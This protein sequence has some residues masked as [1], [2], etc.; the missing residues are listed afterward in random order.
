MTYRRQHALMLGP[1]GDMLK[2]EH[3]STSPSFADDSDSDDSGYAPSA[4]PNRYLEYTK[5]GTSARLIRD[6][7]TTDRLNTVLDHLAQVFPDTEVELLRQLMADNRGPSQLAAIVE[8]VVSSPALIRSRRRL[9]HNYVA[10]WERFRTREYRAAVSRVLSSHFKQYLHQSTITNVLAQKNSSFTNSLPLLTEI[11]T[12]R[13]HRWTLMRLFRRRRSVTPFSALSWIG[14]TGC[15]ELELELI[16]LDKPRRA[17]LCENDERAARAANEDEYARAGQLIECECCFGDYA[18]EDLSCCSEGHFFCHDCLT[19]S[20]KEGLYGQGVLRGKAFV[21]C[22]SAAADPPCRATVPQRV[23]RAAISESLYSEF[24]HAQITDFLAKNAAVKGFVVCPF[25]DYAE[26]SPAAVSSCNFS[27]LRLSLTPTTL[28][29]FIGAGGLIFLLLLLPMI[30]IGALYRAISIVALLSIPQKFYAKAF[31]SVEEWYDKKIMEIVHGV[32][33]KRHGSAFV[34]KNP[35]CSRI[36]CTECN[37]EFLPFHKCFEQEEDRMRVYIEKA[38]ADA[39]KRTC[40][41]CRVSFIKS[42]GCN[43]LTCVCGYSMCY[44]CRKDIRQESYQHFCDH[45]RPIP[46]SACTECDRCD[47]YKIEDEA[48][49]IERAAKEAEA[50]FIRSNGLPSGLDV[51]GKVI[52]P[53]GHEV[54]MN[55]GIM[56]ALESR[57]IAMLDAIIAE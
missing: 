14:R 13:T 9:R 3:S 43:K 1:F 5:A 2:Y 22:I 48:I 24:E 57:C 29:R 51:S 41:V 4:S 26:E 54:A 28:A 39:V 20:V 46:G 30:V 16:E 42:E 50:E 52:G 10:D 23:L 6:R 8:L 18:W 55:G 33:C 35:A 21:P 31:G 12:E 19:N 25:C 38:M 53:G 47:L 17:E 45:F 44:V 49:S 40:P 36:S 32:F 56:R 37:K 15:A 11:A 27:D 34:C 7:A